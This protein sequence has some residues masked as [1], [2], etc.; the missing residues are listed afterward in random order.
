MLRAAR[1][2][3]S[4]ILKFRPLDIAM[5]GIGLVETV[6]GCFKSGKKSAKLTGKILAYTLAI[7]YPFAT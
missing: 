4:T 6:A 1:Q 7:R 5:A 3:G 2:I